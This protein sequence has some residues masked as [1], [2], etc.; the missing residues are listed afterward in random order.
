MPIRKELFVLLNLQNYLPRIN[1]F[2]VARLLSLNS[3]YSFLSLN[4]IT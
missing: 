2:P 3:I 1:T 4:V